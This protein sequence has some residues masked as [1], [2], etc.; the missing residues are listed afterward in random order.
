MRFIHLTDLH[1][2]ADDRPLYGLRP[3]QR[4]EAA[5]RCINE[6]YAG[7]DLVMITGDLANVGTVEEYHALREI[8][9]GLERPWHL[10]IGNHD[11][12]APFRE[13]FP[14]VP[15]DDHGFVQYGLDTEAGRFVVLD[16]LKDG[17]VNGLLCG[18]RLEWLRAELAA[19]GEGDVYLFLHHP[20]LRLEGGRSMA[21][22]IEES[23]CRVRHLFFGH[24]HRPFHGS[25]QG[26]PFSGQ[27][28]TVHQ[29]VQDL[30]A[31]PGVIRGCHQP[32]TFAAVNLVDG[33]VVIITHNFTDDSPRFDLRSA[34]AAQAA[35]PED[36]PPLSSS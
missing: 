24:L 4:L 30:L 20:P 9:A 2:T 31:G 14:D 3:R 22:I 1:I 34:E 28:S 16:T 23:P 19:V 13:V 35:T 33:N 36:L 32:P 10:L 26:I 11:A 5:I 12:R 7:V 6:E 21:A 17:S 15:V 27:H 25:W 8:L 29:F 18:Q